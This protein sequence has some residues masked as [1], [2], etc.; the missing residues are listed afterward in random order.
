MIQFSNQKLL[1][2]KIIQL[3]A[4]VSLWRKLS[5][6]TLSLRLDEAL[7]LLLR[8]YFIE[9][10]K[11]LLKFNLFSNRILPPGTQFMS[12]RSWFDLNFLTGLWKYAK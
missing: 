7:S 9:I 3:S 11:N 6:Q 5:L 8:E 4:W 1:S 12:A 2:K 10:T